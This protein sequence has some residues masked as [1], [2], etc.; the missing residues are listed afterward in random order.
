MKRCQPMKAP[1]A[2]L[3]LD[4]WP[5]P[6]PPNTIAITT[7]R[8]LREGH[9]IL[10]VTHDEEGSWQVLCGT[11]NDPKDGL[12]VCLDCMYERDPSIGELAD[13]PCGW[14]AWRAAA[15]APWQRGPGRRR[16]KRTSRRRR[17]GPD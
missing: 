12:V 2:G 5:F 3:Q 1:I 11:T 10:L 15:D 14:R 16:K 7:R 9:P 6:D 13:L 8:V 4:D 17:R